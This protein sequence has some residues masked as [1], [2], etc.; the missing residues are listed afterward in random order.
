MLGRQ[1]GWQEDLFV[2]GP[3]RD[4]IP[5]DHILK[6][7]DRV[8][9]LSWLRDA[10]R[11]SYDLGQG[12]PG[13]DP[14]AAVRLMLAGLFQGITSDRKLLREAQVNLA[15]RWFAGYRLHEQ[16][17]DH[18]SLTRIRQRWGA[19]RFRELFCKSVAAC[20]RAGLI[21]GQTVHVDASL[22]RADVS[23]ESLVEEHV[24]QVIAENEGA[25]ASGETEIKPRRRPG[26]PRTR[27]EQ[28]KK[29]SKTD[30]EATMA[31]SSHRRRMEPCFKD[32]IV[33]D[34]KAG[35]ILDVKVT[36][37]EASECKELMSQL[38]RVE[39]QTGEKVEVVT[40]DAGYGRSENYAAL[41]E[42]R[43]QAAVVPQREARTATKLPLRRF[44]YDAKHQLVRCPAGK[45]LH[46]QGEAPTE[47]GWIYRARACDCRACPLK[48]RCVPRT[49]S[50]RTV[51]IVDGYE[52]LLRARRARSRGWD[53]EKREFYRRHQWWVEG[54][55]G[56]AKVQHGLAR[57]VRRGRW[58]VAIQA[59][60]T[61]AVINLKRLAAALA[62]NPPSRLVFS[63][64][65]RL[66]GSFC[67]LLG[68][69]L[70]AVRAAVA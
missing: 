51:L 30:P 23:W 47:R 58:N 3:L 27:P 28:R 40:A 57:A 37:G 35:V 9:E 56:E 43:V 11:D 38:D 50:V 53:E 4:L 63:T 19:R 17:P 44:K 12:R 41:E 61:A 31:T 67:R 65:T 52:A 26:R 55:H 39:E 24:E 13:I 46:R 18:S 15:I 42:R 25:D 59:Y 21:D 33:V 22:I 68:L 64:L 1:E 20:G 34:N 36:T 49:A 32:H 60:L 70:A 66:V 10:V 69:D 14:E 16:L 8:L 62:G 5:D 45:I 2:A 7:V 29:R 48:G 6:R 54:R